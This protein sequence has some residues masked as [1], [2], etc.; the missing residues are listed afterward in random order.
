MAAKSRS[1]PPRPIAAGDVVAAFSVEPGEWTA[2]Q[3]VRIDAE[4]RKAAVL[5]LDWSGP[6]PMPVAELGDVSPLR[7]T[8]HSWNGSLS[9][10]NHEWG[11][12]P[13]SQ[14]RRPAAAPARRAVELV[15]LRLAAR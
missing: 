15:R 11:A 1:A 2:A 3:I 13:Q 5:E 10:C 8:H 9:Y 6:E 12:S 7:L 4:G 14:G